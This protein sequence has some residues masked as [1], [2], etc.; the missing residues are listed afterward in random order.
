MHRPGFARRTDVAVVPYRLPRCGLALLLTAVLSA[1]CQDASAPA[2]NIQVVPGSAELMVGETQQFTALGARGSV[3]WSTS[4]EAVAGVVEQTGFVTAAGRGSATV[5]AASAGASASAA[6]TVLAPPTLALSTPALT[7]DA[8][9]GGTGAAEQTVAVTNAGDGVLAGVTVGAIAW[10]AGGATD[11]LTVS[12][13]GGTAPVT[14]TFAVD[15]AGLSHGTHTATVPV[16]A[17]GVANSPQ[18]VAVTFNFL[19]PAS[20]SLSRDS[21]V[22]TGLADT[23]LTATVSI[24]NGGDLPLTGLATAVTYGTGADGWLTASLS[25]GTAPAELSLSATTAGLATGTYAAAVRISSA[26][27]GV[28]DRDLAVRLTVTPGPAIDL[29]PAGVTLTAIYGTNAAPA[30]VQVTNSGGGSLTGL[31]VGPATYAAG[32]PTGWLSAALSGMTAPA[33]ITLEAASAGLASGTYTAT[34]PVTSPV[35]SNSPVPLEVTLHVGAAP[36]IAV[37]PSQVVFA[38]WAGASVPGAQIIQI[39]NANDGP[40]TGLVATVQYTSG[41]SGW[42]TASLSGGTAPAQ[43]LLQPITTN[44]PA[45]THTAVVTITSSMPGVADATIHVSYV[46][47]SFTVNVYP[48]FGNCT[49]CHDG[50]STNPDWSGSASDVYSVLQGY[51]TPGNASTSPI[52]CKIF[53]SCPHTGGKYDHVSGFS[54]ALSGWINAGAPFQ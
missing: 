48:Y 36:V 28:A 50:S 23:T 8:V 24:T 35:A 21:V 45:G 42:L 39:T 29:A 7:F 20:I 54:S 12:A 9:V 10:G 6:V 46:M 14:L 4:D 38:A 31:G 17:A 13:S 11:W 15:T 32:Q 2:A 47:Q 18:H 16:L 41:S 43:L 49:G 37:N 26:A 19:R 33:T 52:M 27:D 53:G 30:T 51:I 25:G 34:L 44:L 40:L 1:S 22:M 5:T 3:T